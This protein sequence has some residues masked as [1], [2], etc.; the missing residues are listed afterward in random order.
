MDK[1][2][3]THTLPT[4]NQEV[5]TLNRSRAEA[6]AAVSSLPTKTVQVETGSQPNAL[7]EYIS[8]DFNKDILPQI[9]EVLY[10]KK[11]NHS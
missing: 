4:L 8:L 5:E 2:Q 6:E 1:F 10:Q 7:T 11:Y 9:M 3:D